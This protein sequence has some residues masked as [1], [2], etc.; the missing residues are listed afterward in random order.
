MFAPVLIFQP[1][2]VDA[3]SSEVAQVKFPGGLCASLYVTRA[4]QLDA[5][6]SE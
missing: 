3:V 5:L 6:E 4:T 1:E 2:P